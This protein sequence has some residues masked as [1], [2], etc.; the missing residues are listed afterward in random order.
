MGY[1][2]G[3][4]L[5]P[6]AV[7]LEAL[8]LGLWLLGR[9][10]APWGIIMHRALETAR[11][12]FR[13]RAVPWPCKAVL[14]LAFIPIPGPFDEIAAALACLLLSR[15]RP[16][17]V[18]SVWRSTGVA[19]GAPA[20]LGRC[21]DLSAV[22]LRGGSGR[23]CSLSLGLNSDSGQGLLLLLWAL[24]LCSVLGLGLYSEVSHLISA[25]FDS[26]GL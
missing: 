6:E 7:A 16:G 3:I 22:V 26:A 17:L 11:A 19:T 4:L 8:M 20:Q 24:L 10:Y 12:L 1:L 23:P 18:S 2:L 15:L 9:L 25:S 13:S 21:A 5:K 14:A